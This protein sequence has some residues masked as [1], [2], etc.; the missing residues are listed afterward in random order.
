MRH[1]A[2]TGWPS[3]LVLAENP[4]FVR[5]WYLVILPT[6]AK[7]DSDGRARLPDSA[8]AYVDS[9][10]RR[11]LPI[12]DEAHVR[13]ALARF[14]QV[15]FES[16]EARERARKRLLKAAK[17]YGIMPIG[18]ITTQIESERKAAARQPEADS[19]SDAASLPT[20]FVTLLMT[21]IESSTSLLHKLGDR[22]RDL[23][24]GVRVILREHAAHAG[25]QEIDVRADE[26]FAVF[27]KA[28][29]A[30]EAATAMQRAMRETS[31]PD[32]VSVRVRVGIH[33]GEPSLTDVGY[34]GMAV[35]TAA[36]V[37]SAA[38]GGQ[39]IVSGATNH[40]IEEDHRSSLRLRSLGLHRLAGLTDAVV[41]YQ[42]E[43]DGLA[44]DFPAPSTRGLAEP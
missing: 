10:G 4:A 38:H 12:N 9:R 33:S 11:R 21:D 30:I 42:V 31:W 44:T 19:G 39:I 17:K 22:Y 23:L 36:R 15:R 29:E 7:L 37:C 13:N 43:A 3:F 35:H 27:H 18:F 5:L 41:L 32:D 40:S 1:H 14:N 2:S 16:D 24:N 34:I 28:H 26:F 20:G 8:F 25:G 6:M